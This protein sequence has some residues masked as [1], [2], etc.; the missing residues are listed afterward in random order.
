M[1]DLAGKRILIVEDEALVAAMLEDIV[2]ELGA[3]AVGSASTIEKALNLAGSAAIDAAILDVNIRNQRID[4]V[5]DVLRERGVPM[6]FATGYGERAAATAMGA[7]IID[8]P[9]SNEAVEKALMAALKSAARND[10]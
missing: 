5:A 3:L 2:T 1:T 8:K 7:P 10:G 9:Y 6:V 4:P